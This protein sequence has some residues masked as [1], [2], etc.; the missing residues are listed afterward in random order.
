MRARFHPL[1]LWARLLSAWRWPPLVL[2]LAYG[3]L[4]LCVWFLFSRSVPLDAVRWRARP[5][6]AFMEE[7][8]RRRRV[9]SAGRWIVQERPARAQ[10]EATTLGP[11]ESRPSDGISSYYVGC[12]FTS[13]I[14]MD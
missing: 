2:A 13:G 14:C 3:L 6:D 5:P 11:D 7:N 1:P 8:P 4:H 12:G 10:L 9:R